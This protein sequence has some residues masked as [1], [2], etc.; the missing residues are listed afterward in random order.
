MVKL[1]DYDKTFRH[2][3]QGFSCF[4]QRQICY[5]NQRN[6]RKCR[7]HVATSLLFSILRRNCLRQE[8]LLLYV[9]YGP[10]VHWH[11]YVRI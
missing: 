6:L 4:N 10:A 9:T 3:L 1:V 8:H 11:S 7:F 2:I 5:R